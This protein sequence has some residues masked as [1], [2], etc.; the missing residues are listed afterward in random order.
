MMFLVLCRPYQTLLFL[1][2][3]K[4]IQSM[5]FLVFCR[6][7]HTV[8]F[9]VEEKDIHDVSCVVLPHAVVPGGG[10]GYPWHSLC[11][12][13]PTTRCCSWWR[14]RIFISFLVL[15]RP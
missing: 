15:C 5:T 1:V 10:E 7:H 3:V 9:L 14:R 4:D 2:E 6:P 13:G 11:C 12:A 8:L